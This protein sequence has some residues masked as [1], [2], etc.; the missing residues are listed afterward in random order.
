MLLKCVIIS[1]AV[2]AS[3][4]FAVSRTAHTKPTVLLQATAADAIST[5]SQSQ[6]SSIT[7]IT[8]QIPDLSTKPD[9]NWTPGTT[10]IGE[11]AA[12]MECS[13]APGRSNIAWLTSLSV[14]S[15]LSSLTIFNGPLTDVPHLVSRCAVV[16]DES[17]SLQLTLDFRP[18]AYGAYEMVKPDG[19][20]PGPDE[21]G[22]KSFEYFAARRAFDEFGNED[23]Q[24][25]L[26]TTVASLDGAV[27]N[28]PKPTELDLLTRSPLYT[29]VTMP[30]TDPNVAAVA[31]ARKKCV[32]YWLEW[33]E[34][35]GHEH[36]PGAPINAQYMYDSKYRQNAYGALLEE[37]TG[38]FGVED[39]KAL[40]I[41]ES[42]PLDEGYVGGGS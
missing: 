42:G 8:S 19:T 7:A 41:G 2:A 35:E 39:G 34:E 5:L 30:L 17:D 32:E 9:F 37:Y 10:T 38:V 1:S 4:A 12:T 36:K 25:F 20:Y 40:A 6:T 18:R 11:N 33:M 15:K 13:E 31:E 23:I 21:L 22:R 27:P 26:S 24:T 3:N 28:D 29:C 14:E 16:G